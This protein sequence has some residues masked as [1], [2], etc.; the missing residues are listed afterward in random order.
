MT[1]EGL[2]DRANLNNGKA[3]YAESVDFKDIK[4][5]PWL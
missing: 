3:I 2:Q 4:K 5:Q 1:V